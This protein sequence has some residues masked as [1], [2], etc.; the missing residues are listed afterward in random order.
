EAAA[1]VCDLSFE[2]RLDK[3]N[4]LIIDHHATEVTPKKAQLIHN[5]EKSAGL[6]C[7]ELC[8]DHEMASPELD[9]L[10]HLNNVADLFLYDDPEFG[11][12]NGYA[13]PATVEQCWNIYALLNGE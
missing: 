12:A 8:R 4:W 6:L 7:Y 11:L 9:R 10:I 2:P 1:W 3:P 13:N 5:L